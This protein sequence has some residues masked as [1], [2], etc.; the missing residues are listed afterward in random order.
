[1]SEV[2]FTETLVVKGLAAIV[3]YLHSYLIFSLVIQHFQCISK[4]TVKQALNPISAEK[5]YKLIYFHQ[6]MCVKI[7]SNN[8]RLSFIEIQNS[9]GCNCLFKYLF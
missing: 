9:V 5:G 6:K 3:D 7:R 4:W 2:I 1:M 8:H